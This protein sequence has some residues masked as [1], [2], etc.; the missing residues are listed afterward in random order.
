MWNAK[1][2]LVLAEIGYMLLVK[3][4]LDSEYIS[5]RPRLPR[6]LVRGSAVTV[7]EAKLQKVALD[8]KLS[9]RE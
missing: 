5:S 3:S 2:I 6:T 4:H 1:I 9:I 8:V 7:Q